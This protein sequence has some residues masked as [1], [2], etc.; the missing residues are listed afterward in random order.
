M[1]DSIMPRC[2]FSERH[3]RRLAASPQRA[4]AELRLIDLTRSPLIRSLFALRGVPA[5]TLGTMFAGGFRVLDEQADRGLVVGSVGRFW[6]SGGGIEPIA[7]TAAFLAN[8]KPG[9]ARLAW[10]FEF[11]PLP[12]GGCEAVTETRILCNDFAA[13]WRMTLY[14]MLI[15]PASGMI[16]REMLRLLA[17]RCS[18]EP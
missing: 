7:D 4:M 17:L 6:G 1:I 16:R 8:R 5:G 15:R 9:C 11:L 3:Q 13:R 2:H 12:D 14:W 10:A 18:T